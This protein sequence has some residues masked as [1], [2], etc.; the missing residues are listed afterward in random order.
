MARKPTE[1]EL[2]AKQDAALY[3]SWIQEIKQAL[4]RERNYRKEGKEIVELYE[5]RKADMTPFAILYSNTETL[6]P[7]VYNQRP[8]PFVDRRF[9]DP[10]PVGKSAAETGTRLLKFLIDAESEDYDNFDELI[11]MA[12]LNT[13]ITN[14]GVTRA[15]FEADT[16]AGYVA[17]ECVY[18]EDVRW[19]KFFHGYARTWKKV[20]WIGFEW[21]MSKEEVKENFPD[22]FSAFDFDNLP[23]DVQE[24]R[25]NTDSGETREERTGAKLAKVYEIWDKESRK[26]YFFSPSYNK[27]PLKVVN[28][29]LGLLNFFPV[30]KPLNFMRKLSTLIPTPLYTQYKSQAKELNELTRRLKAIIKACKVRGMYNSTVQGIE[31]LLEAEDNEVVPVENMASMPE[32]TT[33]DKMFYMMPLTDLTQAAQA[34]YEQREKVKNVIY[35]ITGISDIL[36]GASLA[37]ETATAQNIKNQWGTLRLKRMQKEVQRYCRDL[38]RIMLEIAA[39]KFSQK[40]VMAMTGLPYPTKAQQVQAQNLIS[41]AQRVQSMIPPPPPGQQPQI[42]PQFQQLLQQAQQAQAV[43]AVPSWE[44]VLETLKNDQ[45]RSYKV[46]I[47]TNSTIDAEATQDKQDIAELLN[48][49]SQFLNGI[50]P[51]VENGSMPFD[52]AKGIMLAISRRYAFGPQLEDALEQM[53]PPAPPSDGS[54]QADAA[55]LQAIQAQSQADQAAAQAQMQQTQLKMAAEADKAQREKESSVLEHQIRMMELNANMQALERKTQLDLVKHNAQIAAIE[56]KARAAK[57]APKPER[58]PN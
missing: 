38:L 11:N 25:A 43:I 24:D 32:G 58:K 12:V 42:P 35:E 5:G 15:K 55:K 31:K 41:Q 10:D 45:I 23:S 49:L 2:A 47:E 34:L 6:A 7:A 36:R 52:V 57:E 27:G 46:D 48:A 51:L 50:A 21:D 20:P 1:E 39:T 56:A 18:A 14:R 9:K 53:K 3:E 4:E 16:D 17:N 30:P 19:D 33:M 28:D 26:V 54:Q 40:T 13:L 22:K 44:T 29:P 37:S 8:I